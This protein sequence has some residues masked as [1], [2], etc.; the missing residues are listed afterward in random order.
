MKTIFWSFIMLFSGMLPGYFAGHF[1]EKKEAATANLPVLNPV[2]ISDTLFRFENYPAGKTPAGWTEALTGKGEPCRWEI[3]NDRGNKVLAQVSSETWEYR[4][5]LLVN[6][7]LLYKNV[8]ISVRFKAVKGRGDQGGGP[9]WRYT[10]ADNYYVARAN[11]LENNFRLYK[12]VHGNRHLLKSAYLPM[13]TGK[14][15]TLKVI[16]Y[17]NQIKCYFNGKLELETTDNTFQNKGKVGLWTKSDA[18]TWFDNFR[19][20]L[21][22][23]KP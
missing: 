2:N 20:S 3:V 22:E 14:W 17:G 9:V 8:E 4:F 12:V 16:M 15:Y 6:N 18:V 10:D 13:A 11:P 7:T 23:K 21:P 1:P 5:N 19:V